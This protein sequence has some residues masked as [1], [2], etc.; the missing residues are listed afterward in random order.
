MRPKHLLFEVV[1]VALCLRIVLEK[2]TTDS[3]VF[4]FASFYDFR[5][6]A[7]DLGSIIANDISGASFRPISESI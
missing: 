6:L 2:K 7:D 5:Q 4:P 1:L 3:L